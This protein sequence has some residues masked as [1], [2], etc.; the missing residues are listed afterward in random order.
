MAPSAQAHKRSHSLLL[1]QKLLNLRDSASPLTLVLDTLEQSATPLIDEFITRAKIS[2]TRIVFIS[3]AT[4][5]RP[6]NAD[7]F[8]K[9]R[10]KPLERLRAEVASHC[11]AP[12]ALTS[13]DAASSQKTLLIIDTLNPLSTTHPRLLT[14][15]LSSLLTHPAI[16]LVATYHTDVPLPPSPSAPSEYEPHPL[17]VLNH[18]ATAVLRVSSL[19]QA[20]ERR[21]AQNRSLPEPEWGLHEGREGVLVG[22]KGRAGGR[23]GGGGGVVVEMELRR[24]SGRAVVERFVLVPKE[25]A[26]GGAVVTTAAAATG[27][28]SLLSD[29]PL[30]AAP[31]DVEGGGGGGGE[32]DELA[33]STFNLGLTEKQRKDREGIVLPYFDAQ[34]DVG[35][36]EGGRILYEMGREDDFDDEEDEI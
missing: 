8:I 3:F 15:F 26:G 13:R 29:H 35:G 11:P 19:H 28:V 17:T 22:V 4:I 5:K 2:H 34:E 24:R 9:A 23:D 27:A 6:N 1:L 30:F 7:V 31:E 14:T 12:T 33:G 32:D 20:V 10:G 21:R 36:G 16:S 25:K 18:L